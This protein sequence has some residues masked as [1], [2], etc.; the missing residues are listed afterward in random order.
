MSFVGISD[1][2]LLV[3]PTSLRQVNLLCV[4]R[5]PEGARFMQVRVECPYIQSY[6][7]CTTGPIED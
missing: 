2:V 6:V 5:A 4:F 1:S 7:V 3:F